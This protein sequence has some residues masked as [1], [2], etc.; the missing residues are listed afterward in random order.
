[1]LC[2]IKVTS[3]IQSRNAVQAYYIVTLL[4]IEVLRGKLSGEVL[5]SIFVR[6]FK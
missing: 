1:M 3:L 6:G 2:S 5:I 4:E